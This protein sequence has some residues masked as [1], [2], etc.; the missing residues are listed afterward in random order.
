MLKMPFLIMFLSFLGV[1]APFL[2]AQS[3]KIDIK[4]SEFELV[5]GGFSGISDLY[6]SPAGVVYLTDSGTNYLYRINVESGVIDSLGGRGTA[7]TQFISPVGVYATNDLRIFVNDAGNA[8]IQVYDRRFQPMGQIAYPS[9]S[10]SLNATT[11]IHVTRDAEVVF[12][13]GA[14]SKL[15]GTR[16]NYEIDGLYRPDVTNL[17]QDIRALRSGN[18]EYLV[19]DSSGKHVFR[20]QDNGRYVGFWEWSELI[21]DIRSTRNGYVLLTNDEIVGLS[22]AWQ[23]MWRMGHGAGNARVVFQRGPWLY[24][25]TEGAIYRMPI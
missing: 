9:G 20:Y 19:I 22:G 17:G 13:D 10:R 8:R 1:F 11:G 23:P 21:L 16:D 18:S 5:R 14:N 7:S 6:V 15:V 3:P 4:T 12:W 25:A 2:S 24:M